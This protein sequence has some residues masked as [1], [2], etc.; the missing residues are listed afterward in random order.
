MEKWVDKEDNVIYQGE[1][2][3][4]LRTQIES[5]SV[6]LIFVDPPYNIGKTFS[7]FKDRWPSDIE[8]AEWAYKWIDECIRILK[9]NG[10]MYLMTST[11]AMPYLDLYVRDKL[12]ILSRIVWFYDSSGVQAK[13]YFGM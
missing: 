6:D 12:E 1:A 9:P 13:K 3:E 8:Y 4:I 11:Q 2:L 10:S 7:K 5:E